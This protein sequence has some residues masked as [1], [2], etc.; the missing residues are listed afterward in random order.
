NA[1]QGQQQQKRRPNKDEEIQRQTT[2]ALRFGMKN[3]PLMVK[4]IEEANVEKMVMRTDFV[5]EEDLTAPTSPL[6][7]KIEEFDLKN[8][9]LEEEFNQGQDCL[10]TLEEGKAAPNPKEE[11]HILA[12]EEKSADPRALSTKQDTGEPSVLPSA[13]PLPSFSTEEEFDLSNSILESEENHGGQVTDQEDTMEE[14]E[15]LQQDSHEA[16]Y[17]SDLEDCFDGED[18]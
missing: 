8:F 5:E 17:L 7:Q 1:S 14:V 12:M 10:Q 3:I 2:W 16:V 13:S 11:K 18:P 15:H 9:M 4:P 6:E